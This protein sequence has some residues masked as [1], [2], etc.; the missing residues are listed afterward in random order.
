MFRRF[1]FTILVAL[2]I[3]SCATNNSLALEGEARE[4]AID[5]I[6]LLSSDMLSSVDIDIP[7]ER[8]YSALPVEYTVYEDYVPLYNLYRDHYLSEVR[9]I[10]IRAC[11]GL[12]DDLYGYMCELAKSPELYIKEDTSLTE[13]IATAYRDVLIWDLYDCLLSMD[14]DF[15]FAL[16]ES[17]LEYDSIRN[18][19]ANLSI[20]GSGSDIPVV[21][22]VNI[23]QVATVSIDI[24]LSH[25]AEAESELKNRIVDRNSDTLYSIFWE[26]R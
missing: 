25:L 22:G 16:H 26:G 9:D 23:H 24:L 20:V 18:A 6:E 19:Y 4:R 14:E 5:A 12:Y 8:L 21:K 3:V 17:K 10:V 2:A 13:A 11:P 7:I 15:A 1:I